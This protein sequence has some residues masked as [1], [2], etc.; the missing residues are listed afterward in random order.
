MT[1]EAVCFA[2]L[3]REWLLVIMEGAHAQQHSITWPWQWRRDVNDP[4][5]GAVAVTNERIKGNDKNGSGHHREYDLTTIDYRLS[6]GRTQ[7]YEHVAFHKFSPVIKHGRG[8]ESDRGQPL[9]IAK[10]IIIILLMGLWS[11]SHP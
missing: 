3:L 10:V 9:H 8:S 2:P 7:T 6:Q 4:S 5:S 11:Q 1:S